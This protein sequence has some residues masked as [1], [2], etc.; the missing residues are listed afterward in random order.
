[1]T[2]KNKRLK[3]SKKAK[4]Q[5]LFASFANMISRIFRHIKVLFIGAVVVGLLGVCGFYGSQVINGFIARPITEVVVKGSFTY[6]SETDIQTMIDAEV[7]G[8]FIGENLTRIRQRLEKNEWVSS[9]N[10]H[11]QWPGRLVVTINEQDPIARWGNTGF[12]NTKGE[13]VLAEALDNIQ[14]LPELDG[15]INKLFDIIQQYHLLA[16]YFQHYDMSI[17][18]LSQ[19]SREAWRVHLN[20]DWVVIL[21]RGDTFEKVQR[22]THLLDNKLLEGERTVSTI[23]IR[24]ANGISVKWHPISHTDGVAA[25]SDVQLGNKKYN[26]GERG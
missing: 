16:K 5:S 7:E 13:L 22:L 2:R 4:R 20:N 14:T 10:L 1:M 26:T 24:Y 17:N 3:A 23:D 8:S 12:V 19:D 15:D 9:V 21:G 11:R 18:K 6:L 25:S